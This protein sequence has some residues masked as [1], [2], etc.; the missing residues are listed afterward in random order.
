MVHPAALAGAANRSRDEIAEDLPER[1]GALSRLFLSRSGLAITRTEAGV[2]YELRKRPRRI[3][4]LAAHEGVTQ[5][6]ITLLVNR[7]QQRGWV[8]REPDAS[9]RRAVL[10]RLTSRGQ[11]ALDR[12]RSEYRALLHEEM[13]AL[14][15]RDIET[16]GRAI[17]ILDGVISRIEAQAR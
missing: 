6:A 16:L 17:E 1:A 13:A 9:D 2:L 12:L 3:T 7:L 15:D 14:G 11:E 8:K 5:P 10:V 4:E